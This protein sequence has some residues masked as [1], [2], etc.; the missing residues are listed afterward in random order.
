MRKVLIALLVLFVVLVGGA[1]AAAWRYDVGRDDRLAEGIV[2]AGVDVGGLRV[3]E[4]RAVLEE[5]V[6]AALAQPIFVR[7]GH[8]QFV[9]SPTDAEVS[10]NLDALLA[11]ALAASRDGNFLTR[12]FRDLT[13]GRVVKTLTLQVSYADDALR[14]FL[15]SV[16]RQVNR[17]PVEAKSAASFAGVRVSPSSNGIAVKNERLS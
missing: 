3:Q 11:E 10:T 12:A 8:G 5:R 1:T 15:R 6:A 13:G 7:Y 14:R 17:K 2:L 9:F 16:E 4:A